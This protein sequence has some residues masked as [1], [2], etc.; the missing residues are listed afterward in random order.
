M[1]EKKRLV[2][3]ISGLKRGGAEALLVDLVHELADEFEQHV[4]YFHDGPH[5]QRLKQCSI[6][7][8][9]ICGM[10][11]RYDPWFFARLYR[12]VKML[13]PNLIHTALWA[14]NFSGR[15]VGRLLN[16]PVVCAIHLGVN[17]DGLIRGF[18]DRYTFH[19]ATKVVAVSHDVA[20][21]IG[22]RRL[23]PVN[24]VQIIQN[25]IHAAKIMQLGKEECV[26][27]EKIG[28]NE[29]HEIFGT[30]GRL[31]LRKNFSFLLTCFAQVIAQRP[32]ARLVIVGTG[33]E[34]Q[35]LKDQAAALGLTDTVRFV[36]GQSAYGYYPMFDCF[37][38]PSL[39]EGLSIA[40]LEAMS[41]ALP[42]IVTAEQNEHEVII[43]GNNGILVQCGDFETMI[44]TM[45][46]IMREKNLRKKIGEEGYKTVLHERSADKMVDSYRKMFRSLV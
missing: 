20:Y 11:S 38:L 44:M 30:V 43:S 16:V 9:Q 40:L 39:Q 18:F 8:Y 19:M 24:D 31:I 4:I 37:I 45:C 33:P 36:T 6:P 21:S 7:T 41:F 35:R 12:L 29:A 1:S 42:C 46:N 27:R 28:L 10:I 25:G 32:Q 2:H 5:V 34:E 14:A 15:V 13:S 26:I 3:V 17:Q 22:R 23:F